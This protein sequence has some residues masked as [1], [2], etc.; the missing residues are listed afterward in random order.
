MKFTAL[1]A[2]ALATA[3]LALDLSEFD[4]A[5]RNEPKNHLAYYRR[6][7]ANL[8]AGRDPQALGDLSAALDI[9]PGFMAARYYRAQLYLRTGNWAKCLAD[10][11][12]CTDERA[13]ELVAK[14]KQAQGFAQAAVQDQASGEFQ[15][16]ISSASEALKL[17]P[18]AVAVRKLRYQC[19]MSA[20]EVSAAVADLQDI[21]NHEKG[22]AESA[23]RLAKIMFLVDNHQDLALKQLRRCISYDPDAKECAAASKFLRKLQ[24]QLQGSPLKVRYKE[25]EATVFSECEKLG[26]PRRF[27]EDSAL[28]DELRHRRCEA[29]AAKEQWDRAARVCAKV[30]DSDPDFLP[31]VLVQAHLERESGN[32]RGALRLLDPL[33]HHGKADERIMQLYQEIQAELQRPRDQAPTKDLYKVLGVDEKADARAIKKAYRALSK[34]YHPDKYRGSELSADEVMAKMQEINEA[35]EVLSNEDS[36]KD[37]DMTRRGPGPG[38]G[39][40]GG[41][42]GFGRAGGGGGGGMAFDNDFLQR[43]AQQFAGGRGNAQGGQRFEFHF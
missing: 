31:A 41:P 16:C 5:I 10:A 36:R 12:S 26:L 32:L 18:K 13:V 34:Q 3:G 19:S 25:I 4:E 43:F 21:V 6:A 37:Y 14:A 22:D 39:G 8:A 42:A 28:L 7:T 27:A 15:D 9:D 2:L 33:I 38:A 20:G 29:F 23:A 35:Y 24:K 30:R 11:E 17:A 40:P 1:L